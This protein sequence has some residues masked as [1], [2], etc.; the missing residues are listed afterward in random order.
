MVEKVDGVYAAAIKLAE[1]I[2][3]SR[4]SDFFL[5]AVTNIDHS[6]VVGILPYASLYASEI[7][8]YLGKNSEYDD[9]VPQSGKF[10]MKDVRNKSK[11]FNSRASVAMHTA[12]TIDAIQNET[13]ISSMNFPQLGSLNIHDNIG[14]QYDSNSRILMNTHYMYFLFQ[15]IP[16][17]KNVSNE[18]SKKDIEVDITGE[19]VGALAFDIGQVIGSLS[20][21][22]SQIADITPCKVISGGI[23]VSSKDFN[24]NRILTGNGLSKGNWLYML[25]VLSSINYIVYLL[26]SM[27]IIDSGWLLKAEYIIYHYSLQESK[28]MRNY[29]EQGIATTWT[30]YACNAFDRYI[31]NYGEF[32]NT[33]FRNCMMHYGLKNK[34][35]SY[36]IKNEDLDTSKLLCGLVESCFPGYDYFSFQESIEEALYE[37]SAVLLDL[38]NIRMET[39]TN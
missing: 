6:V 3:M 7:I 32:T 33:V 16:R 15:G 8:D 25:H 18:L 24:T 29:F 9:G 28:R 14:I 11:L 39:K 10:S 23:P 13:M 21:G 17:T 22:L 4:D 35:G 38:L 26:K 37:L 36:C 5:N 34:D 31:D 12:N 30:K 19:D 20:E 1:L 2:T 27:I